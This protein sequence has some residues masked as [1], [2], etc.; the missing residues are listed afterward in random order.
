MKNN[1]DLPD[2]PGAEPFVTGKKDPFY[3]AAI[4]HDF[5]YLQ[6]GTIDA[7]IKADHTFYR[8]CR[9]IM[10]QSWNPLVWLRGA[11]YISIVSVAARFFWQKHNRLISGLNY[12]DYLKRMK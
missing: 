6:G 3:W 1:K 4:K 8:N 2:G 12:D 5:D 7:M 11:A 10:K 9:G